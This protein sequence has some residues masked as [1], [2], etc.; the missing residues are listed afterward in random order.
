MLFRPVLLCLILCLLRFGKRT[1]VAGV[2]SGEIQRKIE[3][4]RKLATL[5][6]LVKL[7]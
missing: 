5:S 4:L 1:G 2:M 6:S 3:I 7:Y